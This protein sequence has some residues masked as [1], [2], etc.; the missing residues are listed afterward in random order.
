MTPLPTELFSDDLEAIAIKLARHPDMVRA[1]FQNPRFELRQFL[2]ED[3][4]VL[5]YVWEQTES[6][7]MLGF[8]MCLR[9]SPS[10]G[11]AALQAYPARVVTLTRSKLEAEWVPDPLDSYIFLA[12]SSS[13]SGRFPEFFTADRMVNIANCMRA[14]EATEEVSGTLGGSRPKVFSGGNVE[15]M[16]D[17]VSLTERMIAQRQSGEGEVGEGEVRDS[18]PQE[19]LNPQ[20][21]AS[22][23]EAFHKALAEDGPS[24]NSEPEE[25]LSGRASRRRIKAPTLH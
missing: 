10:G 14:L 23:K 24:E 2:V 1:T 12:A 19:A 20:D 8:P 15:N 18:E 22:L 25:E 16:D 21:V 5:G 9:R 7:L 17:A 4:V 13:M 11:V 6:R 3:R